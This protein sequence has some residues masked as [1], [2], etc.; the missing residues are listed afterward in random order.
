MLIDTEEKTVDLQSLIIKVERH[1]LGVELQERSTRQEIERADRHRQVVA[2]EREQIRSEI[3]E[4]RS[5]LAEAAEN[6][7][8]AEGFRA[9]AAA[10]MAAI[11]EELNAA[12]HESES[13]NSILNDKRTHAATSGERR[14][15]RAVRDP[16]A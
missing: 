13:E 5:K 10:E 6:G 9:A 16:P 1:I 2:S 14:R 7:G 8:S 12:R 11:T 15:S 3:E 4:V